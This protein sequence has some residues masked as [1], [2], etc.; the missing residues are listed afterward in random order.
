MLQELAG[1][2]VVVHLGAWSTWGSGSLKGEVV[3]VEDSWLEL[4]TKKGTKLINT[5]TIRRISA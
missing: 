2:R 4:R 1:R 5:E 3:K